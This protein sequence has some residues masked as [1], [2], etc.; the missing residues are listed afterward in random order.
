[1]QA[2][3]HSFELVIAKLELLKNVFERAEQSLGIVD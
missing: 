3:V 2:P 1:M